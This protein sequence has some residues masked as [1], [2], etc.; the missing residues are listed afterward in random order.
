MEHLLNDAELQK[1]EARIVPIPWLSFDHDRSRMYPSASSLESYASFRGWEN[2]QLRSLKADPCTHKMNGLAML[3]SM[4]VFG[5]WEALTGKVVPS[6]DMI[7]DSPNGPVL[8]STKLRSLLLRLTKSII[9]A[10][11][12][13]NFTDLRSRARR[14]EHVCN[15]IAAWQNAF[16]ADHSSEF[17][18]IFPILIRQTA[19]IFD[20]LTMLLSH[21]PRECRE[22][23]QYFHHLNENS[24]F[25]NHRF[26]EYGLC[27]SHYAYLDFV[28]Q[29]ALEVFCVTSPHQDPS[30]VLHRHCSSQGCQRAAS[31][32]TPRLKPRHVADGCTCVSV[33]IPTAR[34]G[35]VLASGNY[36]V[37]DMARLLDEASTNDK[38][39]VPYENK[40]SYVA[41]S[42]VWSHGLGS[43]ADD[44]LPLCQ[45]LR[46]SQLLQ[47]ESNPGRKKLFWIDS[48]CIPK[49]Y[50]QKMMTIGIMDQ[51]YRNA[52]A[53]MALDSTLQELRFDQVLS[54]ETLALEILL[55]DWNQRLWTFQ[56]ARLAKSL[57][58][59]LKDGIIFL[60]HLCDALLGKYEQGSSSP[61]TMKCW[62]QLQC[63]ISQTDGLFGWLD[64]LQFRSCGVPSD[65]A[66]VIATL[67]GND[68]ATLTHFT[69]DFRMAKLWAMLR[70]VPSGI[71]FHNSSKLAVENY[72]WAPRSLLCGSAETG[73]RGQTV[74]DAEVTPQGLRAEYFLV[75]F[76]EQK[77]IDGSMSS[78]DLRL[79]DLRI[80]C[81]HQDN[82]R[83]Q[84]KTTL[85]QDLRLWFDAVALIR[86]PVDHMKMIGNTAIS[87]VALLEDGCGNGDLRRYR[88]QCQFRGRISRHAFGSLESKVGKFETIIIS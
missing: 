60:E 25:Y 82:N 17:Q 68:T 33:S 67:T 22:H 7:F 5:T 48:L 72:R 70:R 51:I 37:L 78:I 56:E 55:S 57:V 43:T 75:V 39:L 12:V 52:V 27:P 71:L 49:D 83:V 81:Y 24:E 63:L 85:D 30:G 44:G 9:Q 86:D 77:L 13:G 45:L 87:A 26:K 36:F 28:G 69:E 29:S 61:L 62:A 53:V 11:H 54:Y 8:R 34:I 31:S 20:A 6:R 23:V 19:L 2:E 1:Y 80:R 64:L 47:D 59:A 40:L 41:F 50:D 21:F 4:I 3:Q 84:P 14:V 66:L 16:R 18:M 46:L 65:E 32:R 76:E 73:I 74:F 35:E 42:H 58:V 38:A 15:S 88:Y 79:Q 10:K